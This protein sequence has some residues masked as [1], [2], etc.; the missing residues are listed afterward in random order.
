[1]KKLINFIAK[2]GGLI[3]FGAAVYKLVK[4][5]KKEL[6][7][8]DISD[9]LE[10]LME[11]FEDDDDDYEDYEDCTCGDCTCEDCT[12]DGKGSTM[13]AEDVILEKIYSETSENE[14]EH[15]ESSEADVIVEKTIYSNLAEDI[16]QSEEELEAAKE[17]VENVQDKGFRLARINKRRK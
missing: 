3:A 12:C 4:L 16:R 10:E 13:T 9:Y 6:D 11:E 15:L 17:K 1:M 14:E 2:L 5:I 7:D 8:K